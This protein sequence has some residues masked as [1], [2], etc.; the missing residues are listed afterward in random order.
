MT[1]NRSSTKVGDSISPP[2][3]RTAND[4]RVKVD[5]ACHSPVT[6]W[7]VARMSSSVASAA[8][9]VSATANGRT[10]P[11]R[12]S[13]KIWFSLFF[14]GTGNNLEADLVLKKHSNIARLHRAHRKTDSANNVYSIYIPGIGTYFREIGDPGGGLLGAAFGARGDERL[15]YALSEFDRRLQ[16]PLA[17]AASPMNPIQEINIAVFGFSRGAALARA[18]IN[19]VMETRCNLIESS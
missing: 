15:A 5:L 4:L 10:R 16:G 12:C 13:Q 9:S 7:S 19:K 6:S 8:S 17:R 1:K 18:F 2:Y 11:E 14:D 3:R